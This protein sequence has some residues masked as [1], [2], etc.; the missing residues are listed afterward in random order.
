MNQIYSYSYR[1]RTHFLSSLVFIR[2]FRESPAM[3]WREKSCVNVVLYLL[4]FSSEGLF[5][6]RLQGF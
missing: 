6:E 3:V 4:T 2:T 5:A 1:H